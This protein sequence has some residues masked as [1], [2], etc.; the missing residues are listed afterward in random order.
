MWLRPTVDTR[1]GP[2]IAPTAYVPFSALRTAVRLRPSLCATSWLQPMSRAPQPTPRTSTPAK[3]AGHAGARATPAHPRARQVSAPITN[4]RLG[5]RCSAR[6]ATSA[7]RVRWKR[8]P[9]ELKSTQG[10]VTSRIRRRWAC[11]DCAE[12]P[13]LMARHCPVRGALPAPRLRELGDHHAPHADH[14]LYTAR[15]ARPP[16][17]GVCRLSRDRH[18]SRALPVGPRSRP[19][20]TIGRP[21]VN[22]S[23]DAIL[24]LITT[25]GVGIAFLLMLEEA[26]ALRKGRDPM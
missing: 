26:I 2:A 24:A 21:A 7:A 14:R 25:A 17:V 20:V 16:R 9:A 8:S 12:Q 10:Y 6:I 22:L 11:D 15:C 3:K 23:P 4:V 13:L 18:P 19:D 5:K 1:M